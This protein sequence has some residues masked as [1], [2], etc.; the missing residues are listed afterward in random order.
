MV[1]EQYHVNMVSH[2]NN[3]KEKDVERMPERKV[4]SKP[5]IASENDIGVSSVLE[6]FGITPNDQTGL[7]MSAKQQTVKWSIIF[8]NLLDLHS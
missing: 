7:K 5:I 1:S 4:I 6:Y 3:N 2:N 8:Y